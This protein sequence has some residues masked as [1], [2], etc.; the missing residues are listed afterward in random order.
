[1]AG[2]APLA[3]VY[4]SVMPGGPL[5]GALRLR[6]GRSARTCSL[7]L[8]VVTIAWLA[9]PAPGAAAAK[10]RPEAPVY[11]IGEHRNV[12]VKMPD[13]VVLR[14]NV[15]F[16]TNARTGAAASGRF[17]VIM[18]Q[19]PYGKDTLG[20]ASGQQGGPEAASETGEVPYLIRRGYIDVVAEVRGTGD[21]QGT[22]NLLDPIQGRDGATL[23]NWAARLPGANGHVGL[24][25][26][27][28]MGLDQFLTAYNLGRG[29]PLKALFPIVAGND[30]Y[31]DIAFDGGIPDAEFDLAAISTIFGPLEEANPLVEATSFADLVTVERDHLPG[32]AS[33]NLAQTLNIESGGDEAY[34]ESYWQ[35]RAPRNML[36]HIVASGVPAYMVGGYF[37][38]YQRGEPLDYSGLQNAYAGRPVGVPM[39]AR[40]R[41]T[42]RYQLLQGPWYH[43]TAGS[44]YD[45]YALQ[46][47]WFDRWLKGER[48]GIDETSTPLHLYELGAQR[49]A[50]AARYPL[51][52]TTP[53]TL[54]LSGGPSRSGALSRNDGVLSP[55]APTSLSG[56]DQALFT[57][58]SSPCQRGTEQWGAGAGA[59][60]F[61]SGQLPP[62]P[63]T[64]DDRSLEVGPGALTYT[65]A[66]LPRATVVAGPI[67]ATIYLT[68]TRPDS[69]LVSN[70]EDVSPNGTST[71]ISSGALLGS[72]R[73]LDAANTWYAPD[74]KPLAPYH[75]YTRAS[76]RAVAVGQITRLDIEIF[77]T[78]DDLLPGHRLRL[79]LTTSDTPHL[80]P[81]AKQLVNLTG[82]IYEVQRN[83]R[84]ASFLEV[85]LVAADA[86]PAAPGVS[87][88]SR[89]PSARSHRRCVER[90]RAHAPRHR[91]S[92]RRG[93]APRFTG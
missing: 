18:V 90:R 69:E 31:R 24:Y 13:G 70:V 82:G 84:A 39:S 50:N 37:D 58:A 44:N 26:P 55:G 87:T 40:Q 3:I 43:L 79:T 42:G 23:V 14:A 19:T 86:F 75:P 85:P 25:G 59:L 64:Q 57:T 2:S 12:A 56:Q 30:T 72:F 74:G 76:V 17:P 28:Y 91:R 32:L 1:M 20:A 66:P 71:P 27:S 11:G 62:D 6:I 49:W 7:T 88:R 54:Y 60:A 51:S 80:L 41:V 89:C 47:A 35:A 48:T 65:S 38:L 53:T 34:D 93:R 21:S 8:G 46:L 73:T 68:S 78:V 63:C 52:E 9:L 67:D 81:T 10:W 29:S 4:D 36:A 5:W 22:F 92:H 61:Q 15:Y 83:A 77:P 45:I 16:P 33:Y